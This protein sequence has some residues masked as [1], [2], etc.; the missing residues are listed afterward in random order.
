MSYILLV[1]SNS[2]AINKSS[3]LLMRNGVQIYTER[4]GREAIKRIEREEPKV[5]FVDNFL[6]DMLGF[7]IILQ[8]RELYPQ[9]DGNIIFAEH[10]RDINQPIIDWSWYIDSYVQ[11]PFS[12]W[13]ITLCVEQCLYRSVIKNNQVPPYLLEIKA[14]IEKVKTEWQ[15]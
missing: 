2:D 12:A 1:S 13:Q 8:M 3:E 5:I 14:S 7:D 9:G 11:K 6:E 4:Y 15:L 10:Y